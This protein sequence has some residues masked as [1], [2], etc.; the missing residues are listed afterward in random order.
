MPSQKRG[1]RRET[2]TR[3]LISCIFTESVLCTNFNTTGK[4][5]QSAWSTFTV[6]VRGVVPPMSRV[7]SITCSFQQFFCCSELTVTG[8]Q[9]CFI[10]TDECCYG[11][12]AATQCGAATLGNGH[13]C[14]QQR[15]TWLYLFYNGCLMYVQLTQ[16]HWNRSRW[17]LDW[18]QLCC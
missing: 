2:P 12:H 3:R 17:A 14:G 8:Q 10:T 1:R 9:L 11:A 18:K 16:F 4:T 15:R 7:S 6:A 13:K 5:L